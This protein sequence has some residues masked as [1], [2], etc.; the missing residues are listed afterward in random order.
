MCVPVT[1]SSAQDSGFRGFFQNLKIRGAYWGNVWERRK[2]PLSEGEREGARERARQKERD[3][4][5]WRER[6][7][8]IERES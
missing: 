7:R 3:R 1:W 8:E 2:M 6:E 5:R 4:E